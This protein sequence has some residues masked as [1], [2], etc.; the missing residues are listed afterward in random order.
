MLENKT[1]DMT[2]SGSQYS[3]V[4]YQTVSPVKRFKIITLPES[5][6]LTDTNAQIK[7]F[8]SA[9][10][11]LVQNLSNLSGK[12]MFYDMAGH[13]LKKLNFEPNC[14]TSFNT[15]MIPNLYI[16][17]AITDKE[18]VVKCIIVR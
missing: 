8:N 12:L 3:F 16:V 10:T 1:I 11:F 17:K 9:G 14:V 15:A 7:I 4:S 5:D 18:E 13:Y 2:L 6:V